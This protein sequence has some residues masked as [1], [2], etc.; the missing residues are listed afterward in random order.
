MVWLNVK[1]K[2]L[3]IWLRA[4]TKKSTNMYQVDAVR[5]IVYIL[6]RSPTRTLDGITPY[7][8]WYENKQNVNHY[9]Y[10]GCLAYARVPY[11]QRRKLDPKR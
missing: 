11:E 9:R 7:E 5:I 8:S 1:I 2:P 6:N 3:L 4:Q 10:F